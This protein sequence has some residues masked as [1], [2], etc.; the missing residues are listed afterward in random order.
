M[1]RRRAGMS[2]GAWLILWLSGVTSGTVWAET[3]RLPFKLEGEIEVG[4]QTIS[5]NTGS[6]TLFEYRD[7]FGKPTIPNLLLKAEDKLG[8]RFLELGGTNMTRTD[9]YYF[10]SGGL[11][12]AFRFD[13]DYNRQPH[14][15]GLNRATIFTDV[16]GGTFVLPPPLQCNRVAAFN[17]APPVPG[18]IAS[19]VDCLLQP[20][21][22]EQQT[23]TA[24]IGFRYLPA[25]DLELKLTG[26]RMNKEGTRPIGGVIGSP[27]SNVTEKAAPRD[28]QI[29]EVGTGAEYTKDWYQVRLNYTASIFENSI[30]QTEW[31]NPCGTMTPPPATNCGNASGIGRLAMLPDNYAHT[32]SGAG[33]ASLPWWHTRLSGSVSYSLWRQN[34]TFLPVSTLETRNFSDAGATSPDAKMN[35]L[36]TNLYLTSRPLRDVTATARYRYYHLDNDTPVQTFTGVLRPGDTDPAQTKSNLPISFRKQ[37][38]SAD[39]AWR[40]SSKLTAKAGYEWEHWGRSFREAAKTDEHIAKASVDYKPLGWLLSRLT[41]SHGVRTIGAEGYVQVSPITAAVLPQFRKFDEA[42]RTRDKGEFFV[43][44]TPVETVTVSASFF[45]QQDHYFNTSYGLQDSKAYGYSGDLAW[46]PTERANFYGGYAHDD[47]QSFQRNCRIPTAAPCDPS[48]VND[49]FA[50]PRDIMDTWHAGMNLLAIPDVLDLNLDYRYTFAR[51]KFGMGGTPGSSSGSEEP[52]SMPVIK[53]VFHVVN[54]SARYHVTSQ[55]TLKLAYLYERYRETDFTVDNVNPSLA[56]S[57]VDGFTPT[58]T[59]NIRSVLI[60]IQHPA[61]EAHFVGF[62]AGYKF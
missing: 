17:A 2:G 22:L 6:P 46:T 31:D 35:V 10:L 58:A 15:I 48:G 40:L 57:T 43:Q 47:Y 12:N 27:G 4:G 7:L 18:D 13:F 36:L 28:E 3:D 24:G 1:M 62:S 26:S 11:Y 33:G 20:T 21:P 61:Y 60:P 34:Q 9:G 39:V 55:W 50:K 5:G 45:A 16:G 52:A 30:R 51:S 54:A 23:D 44:A 8:T 49:F 14:I 19:A 32:F 38:V 56:A 41:Y 25:P 29:Y 59:G 42:D 53:N 37:N